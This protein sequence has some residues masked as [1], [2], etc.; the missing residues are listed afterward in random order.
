MIDP[1]KLEL[2]LLLAEIQRTLALLSLMVRKE[3]KA[4]EDAIWIELAV[5]MLEYL[6][7]TLVRDLTSDPRPSTFVGK[8]GWHCDAQ[9][10]NGNFCAR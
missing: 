7:D 10:L 6:L 4:A 2:G 5:D 1:A 9:S 3:V 8:S